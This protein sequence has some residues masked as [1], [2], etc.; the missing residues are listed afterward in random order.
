MIKMDSSDPKYDPTKPCPNC[1]MNQL[2][3]K[4]D[5][6]KEVKDKEGFGEKYYVIIQPTDQDIASIGGPFYDKSEA[7]EHK[8]ILVEKI[9]KSPAWRIDLAL[10]EIPHEDEKPSEREVE[11]WVSND[12]AVVSD[13]THPGL[14]KEIESDSPDA[15]GYNRVRPSQQI[16]KIDEDDKYFKQVKLKEL[17]DRSPTKDNVA[18]F[19]NRTKKA[20]PENE[21]HTPLQQV[22]SLI[23]VATNLEKLIDPNSDLEDWIGSKIARAL[24]DITDLKNYLEYH[25][26]EGKYNTPNT[27]DIGPISLDSIASRVNRIKSNKGVK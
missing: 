6:A 14:I 24:S 4:K 2:N 10:D 25:T 8:Q 15:L 26:V 11:E 9:T 13:A 23:G 20:S 19:Q 5:E 21:S 27:F 22:K 16:K 1:E 12:I 17:E 18:K 3:T 7:E